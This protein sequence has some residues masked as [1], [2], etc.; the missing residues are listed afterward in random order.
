MNLADV[1]PF[2]AMGLSALAWRLEAQGRSVIHM[3]FGQPA[4]GAPPRALAEAHAR[5][6]SESGGYWLSAPQVRMMRSGSI[7]RP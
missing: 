4:T 5:L 1:A 6:D 3:E 7:A 2:R